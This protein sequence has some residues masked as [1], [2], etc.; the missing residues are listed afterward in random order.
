MKDASDQKAAAVLRDVFRLTNRGTVMIMS[1][2]EGVI[3]I[4]DSLRIGD[5]ES[6]VA[7]IEMINASSHADKDTIGVLVHDVD[8]ATLRDLIGTRATFRKKA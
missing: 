3:N 8:D 2:I 1:K 7:G 6:V 4:G 5:R